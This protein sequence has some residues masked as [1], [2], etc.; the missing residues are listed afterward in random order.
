MVGH[1]GLTR[2]AG[3]LQPE[4]I[5]ADNTSVQEWDTDRCA[6]GAPL[7]VSAT[8]R[9]P[10]WVLE[11]AA[12]RPTSPIP[13]RAPEAP[14]QRHRRAGLRGVLSVV[15]VL[16]L[17]LGAA[18][19][20]GSVPWP[21]QSHTA[22]SPPQPPAVSRPTDR[23]TS[24]GEAA[25]LPLGTPPP[26]PA[27]GGPHVFVTFQADGVTP[28]AYDPCRAVHYVLRPDSAPPGGED[29]VRAAI[30]RLG[31]ATG[32]VFVDDGYTDEPL[33]SDRELFQPDRYGD[34]WAPVLIGWQ[35]EAENPE[36][37]S[38]IV[39]A[40]GSASVSLGD[41][42]RVYVTGTVSLDATQLPGIL[43]GKDGAA[44]VRA[45]VLHELGHL[46]G[47]AHV[48]D[49]DQLM[50]PEARAAV[51]DY[52]AGDLTGLAALGGGACVPDL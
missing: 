13:W 40:A 23:P 48:E 50:Y 41:G 1:A 21:W 2:A 6:D 4:P 16:A 3:P 52:A 35:T 34:R 25:R 51:T 10:Q 8:G 14:V 37:A 26:A 47:L 18:V 43:A 33:T 32:L 17:S 42:P 44:A 46:V 7:P 49:E 27:A 29:V 19:L 30:A 39:G 12:G 24:G 22:V 38:D 31:Q 45:I 5:P 11:E 28:V 15:L 20:T 36:L 9:T